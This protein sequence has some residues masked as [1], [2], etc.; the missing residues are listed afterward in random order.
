MTLPSV[1]LHAN[2]D[3]LELHDAARI[4]RRLDALPISFLRAC[5]RAVFRPSPPWP[6]LLSARGADPRLESA[7]VVACGAL[8][9]PAVCAV[10][11][12]TAAP[13]A[14]LLAATP[15]CEALRAGGAGGRDEASQTGPELV[16]LLR[17][18]LPGRV[19]HLR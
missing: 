6:E 16:E 10:R 15:A 8:L 5:R 14:E 11:R 19:S 3:A 13:A 12:R 18:P 9:R 2:Y 17:G 4:L 1:G 7:V